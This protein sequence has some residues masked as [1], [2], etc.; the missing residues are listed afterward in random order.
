MPPTEIYLCKPGQAMKE[1][2]LVHADIA[3]REDAKSDAERRLATNPGLAKIAYYHVKEDGTF[4]MIHSQT[5]SNVKVPAKATAAAVPPRRVQAKAK[6]KPKPKGI[7]AKFRH[8]L[9]T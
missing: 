3:D 8:W 9:N 5:N 4:R 6:P 7:W 1:G 2:Q